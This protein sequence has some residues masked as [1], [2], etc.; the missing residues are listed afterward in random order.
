[1]EMAAT[2]E[3]AKLRTAVMAVVC[4]VCGSLNHYSVATLFWQSTVD[5]VQEET[6][7]ACTTSYHR[8]NCYRWNSICCRLR[9]QCCS[10]SRNAAVQSH[11]RGST[12]RHCVLDIFHTAGP[13]TD[14]I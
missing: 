12:W 8:D 10:D 2:K 7:T 4:E 14:G 11:R 1:M 3:R 9:R 13:V 6:T 5:C